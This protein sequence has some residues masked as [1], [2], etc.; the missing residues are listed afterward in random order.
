MRKMLTKR[1]MQILELV[2]TGSSNRDIAK[3]CNIS[4][5]NVKNHVSRVMLKLGVRNRT[6]AA[7]FAWKAGMDKGTR[8]PK[9]S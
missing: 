1:E 2:A 7:A 4:E 6:Q 5:Q 9:K 8:Q 3:E